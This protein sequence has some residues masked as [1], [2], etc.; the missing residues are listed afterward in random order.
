MRLRGN[1]QSTLSLLRQNT[2]HGQ[3]N[4]LPV[5]Q[6]CRIAPDTAE[7]RFVVGNY[8]WNTHVVV[9][10]N[11]KPRCTKNFASSCNGGAGGIYGSNN[12]W[13]KSSN[14]RH[15]VKHCT[16]QILYQCPGSCFRPH[17][18]FFLFLFVSFRSCCCCCCCLQCSLV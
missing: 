12:V 7:S 2:C 1:P 11:G 9:L 13:L 16:V 17:L 5:P 14:N 8:N 10:D 6:G 15:A 4:F 3:N 18:S